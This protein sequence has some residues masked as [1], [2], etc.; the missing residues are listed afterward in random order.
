MIEIIKEFI[1]SRKKIKEMEK[2]LQ[3]EREVFKL[4]CESYNC[5][6]KK[7]NDKLREAT[8]LKDYTYKENSRLNDL[9][10]DLRNKNI[11]LMEAL[12]A[13]SGKKPW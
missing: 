5:H 11:W 9:V 8:E 10:F 3:N 2:D 6:L 13:V 1:L 7:I 12:Y 4:D